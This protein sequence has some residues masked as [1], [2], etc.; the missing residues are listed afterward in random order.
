MRHADTEFTHV[1]RDDGDYPYFAPNLRGGRFNHIIH[2][3]LD[4]I[5]LVNACNCEF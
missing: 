2:Q 1:L 3:V 5:S 4:V